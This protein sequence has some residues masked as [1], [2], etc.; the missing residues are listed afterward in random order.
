MGATRVNS[1]S[2]S[3][4]GT[5]TATATIPG[6]TGILAGDLIIV[7]ANC[8]GTHATNGM[9]VQDS[10]NATAY[11]TIKEQDLSGASTRWLQTFFFVT[12]VNI[13]DGSTIT[14]TAYAASAAASL[15]VDIFRGASGTISNA[16]VG[17]SP[18]AGT[19][20]AAPALGAAPAAGNLVLSF[21]SFSSDVVAMTVA[22]PFTS[23]SQKNGTTP[24]VATG[25]VLAADGSSTYG[26]T[27]TNDSSQSNAAVTVAFAV[28]AGTVNPPLAPQPGGRAWRQRY[29]RH[30]PVPVAQ[31]AFTTYVTGKILTNVGPGG[32]LL[33]VWA[34]TGHNGTGPNTG[35]AAWHGSS[36]A[37]TASITTTQAGSRVYGCLEENNTNTTVTAAAATTLTDNQA[38]TNQA[39]YVT[40]KA[41]SLT[42][43][44]GATTLGSS[45][46][47][48]S[49]SVAL[50][51]ILT[52]T[53]LA[54]DV[55]A[56][57]S[58]WSTS[59]TQITTTPFTP[60][61]GALLVAAF[62][63]EGDGVNVQTASVTDSAGLTWTPVVFSC[64]AGSG[65]SGIWTAVVPT[66]GGSTQQGAATLSGQ[67]SI[68]AAAATISAPAALGGTG[69]LTTAATQG[70]T[71]TTLGGTGTLA[72]AATQGTTGT[73]LGGAG[74]LGNLDITGAPSTLGG[75]GSLTTAV[76]Q[77]AGATLAGTGS[78][79]AQGNIAG[80]AT[81]GGTGSL[82][83]L[84]ITGAPATLGGSGSL[85]TAATQGTTGT[86]LGAQG[87]V[88]AP[89]TQGA[90]TTL[91]GS[92]S[93][94]TAETIRAPA[95]LTGTGSL[96]TAETLLAPATLAGTGSLATAETLLAPATLA[97]AGSLAAAATQGA[98][99]SLSGAG[100]L[101]NAAAIAAPA[102][103]A[104]AGSLS[105]TAGAGSTLGGAGSL[106]AQGTLAAPATLTA[107]GS[108]T[109]AVTQGASASLAGTG[110]LAGTVIQR[111]ISTLTGTGSLTTSA[112]SQG[113]QLGGAGS[114]NAPGSA[115]L[116]PAILTGAGSLSGTVIQGITTTLAGTGSLAAA[117]TQRAA[118]VLAGTGSL[119]G[120]GAS[121]APQVKGGSTGWSVTNPYGSVPVRGELAGTIASVTTGPGRS[122]AATGEK[123]GTSASVTQPAGSSGG[124]V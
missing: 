109:T 10:V 2:I 78:L 124:V 4:S 79:T 108:L 52:G 118:A 86:V 72:T 19:T 65:F 99:T 36:T 106:N 62:T 96:A 28:P 95:T 20:C 81:L 5:T 7:S 91:S 114:L 111:V 88:S 29:R 58:V 74:S 103:L 89:A 80:A 37:L 75:T 35:T 117:V 93:L 9:S 53:G 12:P 70:T 39:C 38:D 94:T 107:T 85:T 13:A 82:G 92:G 102:T 27:W 87:S 46:T 24:A 110:S 25:F 100:S 68:N 54:E 112:P 101:T 44:P 22:S 67:G 34:L 121:R 63:G 60:P 119:A 77:G 32:V 71:G 40:C 45:S 113:G 47:F 66:P 69:S 41:T 48:T 6:G 61:A 33:R 116:P 17:V 55:S 105:A 115:T 11:T 97:A 42:G 90:P 30:Q 3:G 98:P 84:D 104:G 15:A 14:L 73:S 23:G 31:T 83:N 120:S 56:P 21:C 8:N 43:T 1:A 50:A 49:G 57:P 26:V 64:I 76:T 123:A 18:A 59:L 51:E 122:A 16:A